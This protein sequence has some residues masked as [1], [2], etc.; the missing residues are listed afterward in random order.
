[1]PSGP[2]YAKP[3]HVALA[4]GIA[5][6]RRA[7]EVLDAVAPHVD[8]AAARGVGEGRGAR[9]RREEEGRGPLVGDD[10][11]RR[12]ALVE[13]DRLDVLD[14]GRAEDR[15]R[16]ERLADDLERVV[17]RV[18]AR[19]AGV[20]VALDDAEGRA[21]GRAVGAG[22]DLPKCCQRGRLARR[23]AAASRREM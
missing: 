22:R 13:A 6:G 17:G 19:L 3:R 23:A 11:V 14:R 7:A 21:V 15:V 16:R 5:V 18:R 8:R 4:L 10:V 20:V 9:V 12:L 1:M 2:A